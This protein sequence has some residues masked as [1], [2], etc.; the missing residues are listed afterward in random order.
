MMQ[1]QYPHE[2]NTQMMNDLAEMEYAYNQERKRTMDLSQMNTSMFNTGDNVNLVEWQLE[3]DNILERIDHLLRGDELKFDNKGNVT[4]RDTQD[5]AKQ[6]FNEYGVQEVLRVLSMYLN[7]NTILSN[8]DE[9]TINW[10]VYDMGIELTD[11]VFMKYNIM[12]QLTTFEECAKKLLDKNVVQLDD[13]E[14]YEWIYLGKGL[15]Q[16]QK[17]SDEDYDRIHE[18]MRFQS[19][20]K[21]KLYMMIV[22][23]IVDTVHSAY[24]RALNGGERESLR[25]ART[26]VQNQPLGNNGSFNNMSQKQF[27][28]LKPTTWFSK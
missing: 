24:L 7:R 25:T 8:Y 28:I 19:L 2:E 1:P 6:I 17:L 13:D 9:N 16:Y 20:E 18:E 23:E 14:Y 5:K 26:V 3:L 22:R 11:L 27:S 21:A 10:K 4:W 15:Y 12:F